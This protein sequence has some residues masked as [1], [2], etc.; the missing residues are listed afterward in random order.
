MPARDLSVLHLSVRHLEMVR[1]LLRQYL[2]DAEVW[3]YGSRVTGGGHEASDLDLV[4]RNP[5]DPEMEMGGLSR[6]REAFVESN[7]PIRVELLDWSRIP[8]SFQREIEKEYV[9]LH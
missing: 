8:I 3:A 1:V 6:L 7:L 2:P 5:S 9:V 4:V